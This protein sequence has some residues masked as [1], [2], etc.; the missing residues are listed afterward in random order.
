[1]IKTTD[2]EITDYGVENASFF[3]GHGTSF[4]RYTNSS[5]GCGEDYSAALEDALDQAAQCGIEIELSI[6]DETTKEVGNASKSAS[7]V[8]SDYCDNP[9]DCQCEHELYYY[10][11]LRW[12]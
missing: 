1:M 10:V 12:N 11:G 3:Q 8:H 7:Q 4:T 2:Y 6:E 9:E 5:L